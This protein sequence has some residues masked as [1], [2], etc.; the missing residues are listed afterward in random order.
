[1]VVE[2]RQ[3]KQQ[4]EKSHQQKYLS[5]EE[6]ELNL[7][8]KFKS[9]ISTSLENLNIRNLID[10]RE[11]NESVITD[12]N[13]SITSSRV[14]G[15]PGTKQMKQ[16][17]KLPFIIGTNEFFS[18]EYLG[19]GNDYSLLNVID[20]NSRK[21][22]TENYKVIEKKFDLVPVNNVI[23]YFIRSVKSLILMLFNRLMTYIRKYL[24]HPSLKIIKMC[25]RMFLKTQ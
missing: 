17:V 20:R 13:V 7:F 12:D 6:R 8:H 16:N 18:N 1:M 9:S 15:N 25:L 11:N 5:K 22:N 4:E 14:F 23:I 21:T 24:S 10:L 19:I 3:N 2:N